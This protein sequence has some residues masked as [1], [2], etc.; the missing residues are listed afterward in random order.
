MAASLVKAGD[1]APALTAAGA[2]V[3]IDEQMPEIVCDRVALEQIF[4]NLVENAV[5]F[6]KIHDTGGTVANNATLP[7]WN[8]TEITQVVR[9]R[10]AS[11]ALNFWLG[12]GKK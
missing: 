3:T 10:L 6:S 2:S 12:G 1:T 9:D 5:K 11:I 4:A 7:A 8:F